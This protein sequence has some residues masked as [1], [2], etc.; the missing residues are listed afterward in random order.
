MCGD[1]PQ[2]SSE[3]FPQEGTSRTVI[4]RVDEALD[5]VIYWCHVLSNQALGVPI[6][7]GDFEI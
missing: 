2:F 7:L 1:R 6:G 5:I 3:L 4:D